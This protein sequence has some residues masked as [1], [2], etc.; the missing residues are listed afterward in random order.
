[1]LSFIRAIFTLSYKYIFLQT[2]AKA[3]L[4]GAAQTMQARRELWRER[5][6][7]EEGNRGGPGGLRSR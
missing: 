4:A 3:N 7:S 2:R 5:D 1:M 6:A